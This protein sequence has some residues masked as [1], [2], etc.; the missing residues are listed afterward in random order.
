V[1]TLTDRR[2]RIFKLVESCGASIHDITIRD[3]LNMP[4]ELGFAFA[5]QRHRQAGAHSILV[6]NENRLGA[7]KR[8]SDLNG[9]DVHAHS[10]D[11]QKAATI[12]LGQLGRG[13]QRQPTGKLDGVVGRLVKK[14]SRFVEYHH[15]DDVFELPVFEDL[16]YAAIEACEKAGLI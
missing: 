3:R 8:L 6:L 10:L 14:T 7:L 1:P 2:D 13:G 12:V 4:F 11:H 9:I 5:V 16:R 15:A